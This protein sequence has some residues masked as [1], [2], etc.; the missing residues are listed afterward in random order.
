MGLPSMK[1]PRE[2]G[3]MIETYKYIHGL[4]SVNSSLLKMDIETITRGH[5]Y[6]LK[7]LR[8]CTSLRQHSFTFRVVDSWN[9]L[10]PEVVDAPSLQAFKSRLDSIWQDKKFLQGVLPTNAVTSMLKVRIA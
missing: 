8:C 6:K 5:K 3:D 4:Y 10:P 9:S 7:K 2:R 1:Y